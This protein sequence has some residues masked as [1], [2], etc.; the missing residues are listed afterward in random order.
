LTL[1]PQ[2]GG[3]DGG[4][5]DGGEDD[6]EM[7]SERGSTVTRINSKSPQMEIL[8]SHIPMTLTDE[9][10][11]VFGFTTSCPKAITPSMRPRYAE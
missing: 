1:L 10:N 6:R 2:G 4:G 11:A 9:T 8:A 3:G 5:G 7:A